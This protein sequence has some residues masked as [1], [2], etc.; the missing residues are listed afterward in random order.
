[1]AD[2]PAT[3]ALVALFLCQAHKFTAEVS[4]S[5]L[6]LKAVFCHCDT[7][8][9]TTGALYTSYVPWPCDCNA[10]RGSSLRRYDLFDSFG[11]LF[12][13]TCSSPMFFERKGAEQR[14]LT[15]GASSGILS[16]V[17]VKSLVQITDHICVGDTIDGGACPWLRN[18]NANASGEARLWLPNDA[19]DIPVDEIPIRCACRRVD[20]V[21]RKPT[22]EYASQPRSKLPW[23]IDPVTNKSSGGFD[24][25]GSGRLSSEADFSIELIAAVTAEDRDPRWVTLTC[26][27]S[28]ADVRRYFCSK[29]SACV[30]YAADDRPEMVHISIRLLESPDGT[31]AKGLVPWNFGGPHVW[32]QDVAVEHT[33]DI[34]R[35]RRA[36]PKNWRRILRE[37]A[38]KE[39]TSQWLRSARLCVYG[40]RRYAS[41]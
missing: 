34:W 22:A 28:S 16:H 39:L 14:T 3:D 26:Y 24:V 10:I 32:R 29:C 8:R 15:Y 33:A 18:V 40:C 30:F 41:P 36:Y 19:T 21:F 11:I 5:S 25:C 12:C 38:A 23:F 37:H 4:Q 31:R 35:G 1:M 9:H 27:A 17:D 20:L 2:R 7:Y 13:D 6:P